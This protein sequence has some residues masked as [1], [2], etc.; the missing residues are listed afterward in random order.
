MA[1]NNLGQR[2]PLPLASGS[3]TAIHRSP[4]GSRTPPTDERH[5]LAALRG[6]AVCYRPAL[7]GLPASLEWM[8]MHHPQPLI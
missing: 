2:L 8:S 7:P 1:R 3:S 6:G 4:S 5:G